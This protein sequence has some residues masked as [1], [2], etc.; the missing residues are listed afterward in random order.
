MFIILCIEVK[1]GCIFRWNF[2]IIN[3]ICLKLEMNKFFIFVF[4]FEYFSKYNRKYLVFIL[5]KSNEIYE[6]DVWFI[7]Y[8]VFKRWKVVGNFF[9]LLCKLYFGI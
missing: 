3:S 7:G 5:K 4:F 8:N 6:N 9:L 1:L 2:I